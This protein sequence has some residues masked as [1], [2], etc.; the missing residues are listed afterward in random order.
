MIKKIYK[1]KVK[2]VENFFIEID[3]FFYFIVVHI[4]TDNNISWEINIK[5]FKG[6]IEIY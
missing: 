2:K 6:I 4:G 3:L 1:E 5:V